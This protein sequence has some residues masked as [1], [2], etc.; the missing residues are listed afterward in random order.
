MEMMKQRNALEPDSAMNDV[1]KS[2]TGGSSSGQPPLEE[3]A[4]S[5]NG[6]TEESY[7]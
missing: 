7:A 2:E 4:P 1:I 5:S 3:T 6:D